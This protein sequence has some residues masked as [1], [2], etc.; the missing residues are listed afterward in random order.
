MYIAHSVLH[1]QTLSMSG[2]ET[3]SCV[4]LIAPLKIR[5]LRKKRR[6]LPVYASLLQAPSSR[7]P[8]RFPPGCTLPPLGVLGALGS[9]HQPHAPP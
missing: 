3:R 2:P 8:N 6:I 5:K 7:L 1:G 9:C 4:H